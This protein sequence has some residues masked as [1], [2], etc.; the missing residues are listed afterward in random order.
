MPTCGVC[1]KSISSDEMKKDSFGSMMQNAF[2]GL[3]GG[4]MQFLPNIMEGLAMKC[5]RCGQWICGKCA[6]RVATSAGAGAIQHSGCGGM[7]ETLK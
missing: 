5:N 4:N 1:G 7:F 6:E 3:P 2:S